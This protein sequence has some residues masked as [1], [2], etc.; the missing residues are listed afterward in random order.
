LVLKICVLGEESIVI[1]LALVNNPHRRND[2][3]LFFVPGGC[4]LAVHIALAEVGIP[5]QLVGI[6]RDKR[7]A[8]GRDFLKINPKGFVPALEFEDGTV[9]A[10]A[11]AILVYIAARAGGTLLPE[12]GFIRW[13]VLEA[14]SFMTTEI[15]GNF[16]PFWKNAP[17]AEKDRARQMLVKH[18]ATLADEIDAR[19]F[20]TGD[21]MTIAD[22]YLF[23]M[24]MW[25]ARH[26]ID[27][28]ERLGKY[29][30]RMKEVPSVARA[31]AEEGLT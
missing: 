12:D 26:G 19:P 28:P 29:F 24:L 17:E 20:L 5:Y 23:V 2:M 31:L 18:Y 9:L 6:T 11:F 7:T 4:S 1:Y 30:S 21:R 22:L 13:K 8:D 14:T 27:V 16:K 10:E 3:K 15:H 25:A